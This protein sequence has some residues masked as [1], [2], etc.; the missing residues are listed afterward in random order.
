MTRIIDISGQKFGKLTVIKM[1]DKRN[2]S[3]DILW[4]CLCDCGKTKLATSGNLRNGDAKSC[5]CLKNID[6][7]SFIGK[8]YGRL[9][10]LSFTKNNERVYVSCECG[11]IKYKSWQDVKSGH[12]KSCGCLS[13]EGR[14]GVD[15]T[16]YRFGKLLV[17]E[18]YSKGNHKSP[19]LWR[20]RCDCGGLKLCSTG[21]LQ[22]GGN[23]SCGCRLGNP[24]HGDAGKRIRM[25][26]VNMM[27]RCTDKKDKQYPTYGGAGVKVCKKWQNYENFKLWAL[28][29][30]Y[31]DELTIDRYPNKRGNYTP[32]NVRWATIKQQQNNRTNNRLIRMGGVVKT[33]QQWSDIYGINQSR[34][35]WRLKSGWSVKDAIT[36]PTDKNKTANRY[37]KCL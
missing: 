7:D 3:N 12:T 13:K 21:S 36:K 22:H 29:N 4:E 37:R 9:T 14:K 18:L 27:R 32:S 5:G 1:S 26:W 35:L 6:Y 33:L 23:I 20:C 10:I 24:T 17:I 8:T 19:T 28:N 30:G 25:I 31:N 2:G 15:L 11:E 34:I 16:G